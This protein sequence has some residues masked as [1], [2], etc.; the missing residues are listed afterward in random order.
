M[1][2]VSAVRLSGTAGHARTSYNAV[3][4]AAL[5]LIIVG[6]TIGVFVPA[7][8]GW[9]FANFYDAG[10]R[11]VA[12]QFAD[13]YHADRWIAGQPTQ[14]SMR[15]W[16]APLSAALFAPLAFLRPER[17][18]IVFKVQNIVVLLAALTLLYRHARRFVTRGPDNAA[19]FA[20]IFAT[21][22]L[23]YQP[24]WTIF[25]VGGQS[26]PTVFLLLVLALL[27]YMASQ[28]F[29]MSLLLITA[30]MIKPA[31]ALMVL[32]LICV[33]GWPFIGALLLGGACFGAL[34]VAAMGWAIQLEFLRVAIEGSQL[35][36]PWQYNSS[37]Y[38]PIENLRLLALM[39]DSTPGAAVAL[40]LAAWCLKLAVVAIFVTVVRRSHRQEWSIPARRHFEFVM[41]VCFWLL[42]SQA[43]WEHYL[44]ML[45][46]PL[47]YFVA[48]RRWFPTTAHRVLTVIFALCVGQNLILM[49]FLWTH[50]EITSVAAL[51]AIG[52][53]KAGPLVLTLIF[54]WRYQSSLFASYTAPE[55]SRPASGSTSPAQ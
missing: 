49:E 37:L 5:T 2:P 13:L 24:F 36:R 31:L 42:I 17:A 41:S 47:A 1:P 38:V 12:G 6:C 26:T 19:A 30:A 23:L 28:L 8:L 21:L 43:V 48:A 54:L 9:D 27:C 25:R 29:A 15:F 51:I 44:T 40:S 10:H 7:G 3:T 22:C 46:L 11:V 14:G 52:L 35:S 50:F 20:A 45:F 18:L 39:P 53:I 16:G 55:W 4:G 32:F 34:S 33:S